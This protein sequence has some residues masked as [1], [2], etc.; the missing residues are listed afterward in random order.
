MTSPRLRR[1]R[2][3]EGLERLAKQFRTHEAIHP[4]RVPPA[5][6]DLEMLVEDLLG[7]DA[8]RF[9]VRS[10]RARGLLRLEWSDDSWWEAWVIVLPSKV[11]MFCDSGGG[12]SRILASGGRNDGDQS[13]RLFL[14][15]LAQSRGEWFGIEMHG[16]PPAKVRASVDD[17]AFLVDLFVE[18]FE[19][20]EVEAEIRADWG[21]AADGRFDFRDDVA[22]WLRAVSGA[23]LPRS[24]RLDGRA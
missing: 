8:R 13:D 9:D 15:L 12:E 2:I 5:P 23:P 19:G 16:G 24:A 6:V 20:T 7:P 3:L 14:E 4:L 17:E 1:V 18:L 11:K 22:R 10:L 21:Q